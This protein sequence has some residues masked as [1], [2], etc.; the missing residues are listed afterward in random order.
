MCLYLAN[1]ISFT[2]ELRERL[3]THLRCCSACFN[4]Y[5]QYQVLLR[6]FR[7]E[8]LAQAVPLARL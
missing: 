8:I 6:A 3:D 7:A 1:D 2:E 5:K 4:L